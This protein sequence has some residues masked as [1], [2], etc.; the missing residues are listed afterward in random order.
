MIILQINSVYKSGSTGWIVEDIHQHM[1]QNGAESYVAY[2]RNFKESNKNI[3]QVG[4]KLDQLY[5][6]FKTR[7][8][9]QHGLASKNATRDLIEK[10]ESINPDIIH[11][12][13]IHGYYLNYKVFFDY[14]KNN[15]YK[16][17]WTLHDCWSFTGHCAYYNY[18]QCDKWQT[19]CHNCPQ[20]KDYP[21]SNGIDNSKNNYYLKK[22]SFANLN[23]VTLVTPSRWLSDELKKSF[24]NRYNVQ[25][26]YNGIDQN[27]F[28]P[29]KSNI[30]KNLSILDKKILLGVASIW[31]RR[32]GLQFILDLAKSIS[33]EYIIIVIGKI[34]DDISNYDNIIHIPTI[35]NKDELASFYSM[36]DI[37]INPTLEDNYPTTNLEA[38]AC[39][40]PVLTFASGG[41]GENITK[42][43][44][45]VIKDKTSS[46]IINALEE[47]KSYQIEHKHIAEALNTF[48][49]KDIMLDNYHSLYQ[50]VL[51]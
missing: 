26:I 50:K 41:S 44:G 4:S 12:H 29:R 6:V 42:P 5:H 22:E 28:Y 14:I 27:I 19:E 11:L 16:V 45:K 3:I 36:A 39:G 51:S 38:I 32:K 7:F 47:I 33:E 48:L 2:G 8:F 43:L 24:L 13:N 17:I 40:T 31:S 15:N 49:S 30:K 1:L 9:D 21:K 37:F 35:E 25:V 46:G 23:N 10:I 20:L 18:A 34:E